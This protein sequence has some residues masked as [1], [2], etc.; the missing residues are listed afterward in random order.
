[1]SD[2]FVFNFEN[3][4]RK[5]R[6]RDRMKGTYRKLVVLVALA[7]PQRPGVLELVNSVDCVEASD[8]QR[9]E[10]DK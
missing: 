5:K 4:W 9:G 1:M 6:N 7:L 2:V 10:A 3:F 8:R